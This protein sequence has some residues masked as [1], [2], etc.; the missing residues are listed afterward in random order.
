MKTPE[1]KLRSLVMKRIAEARLDG[2]VT[3]DKVY[4]QYPHVADTLAFFRFARKKDRL[5]LWAY[6]AQPIIPLYTDNKIN[7]AARVAS[8]TAHFA[9]TAG[10]Q[11]MLKAVDDILDRLE[12]PMGPFLPCHCLYAD[13]TVS[14]LRDDRL[15]QH[16]REGGFVFTS[17]EMKMDSGVTSVWH[18]KWPLGWY[19]NRMPMNYGRKGD[20]WLKDEKGR[21]RATVSTYSAQFFTRF[22][23]VELTHE[24]YER[25]RVSQLHDYGQPTA[26][27]AYTVVAEM[28]PDRFSGYSAKSRLIS[29]VGAHFPDH[30]LPLKHWDDPIPAPLQ[31]EFNKLTPKVKET[32]A[33]A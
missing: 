9:D 18:V 20:A 10:Q 32:A 6:E 5:H 31:K 4:V 12:P 13:G 23:V 1:D 33:K 16:L 27:Q 25:D 3:E 15:I 11:A 14:D 30:W 17:S 29:L 8:V 7:K 22:R 24:Q 21:L 28:P 19:K 2:L 26:D